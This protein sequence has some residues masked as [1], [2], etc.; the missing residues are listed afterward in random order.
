MQM[1]T[2]QW[3]IL[4]AIKFVL[5]VKVS[6]WDLMARA[7]PIRSLR[8]GSKSGNYKIKLL[9]AVLSVLLVALIRPVAING[10]RGA[11]PA[12]VLKSMLTH[13]R[14]QHTSR[15]RAKRWRS[16]PSLTAQTREKNWR[17]ANR[18]GSTILNVSRTRKLKICS[19]MCTQLKRTGQN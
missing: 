7:S 6:C 17:S 16:K 1:A 12:E 5:M 15:N 14:C 2:S 3:L 9:A 18:L 19:V 8:T 11:L 10:K 13:R 4:I